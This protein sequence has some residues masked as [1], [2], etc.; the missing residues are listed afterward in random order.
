MS[1]TWIYDKDDLEKKY[2]MKRIDKNLWNIHIPLLEIPEYEYIEGSDGLY[3][4]VKQLGLVRII[5]DV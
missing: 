1:E 2:L 4:F 3:L 5:T